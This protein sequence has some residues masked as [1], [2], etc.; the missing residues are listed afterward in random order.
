[1][2]SRGNSTASTTASK[3]SPVRD[4]ET[5]ARF[6]LTESLLYKKDRPY[7]LRTT[8]WIPNPYT[9][10]SVFRITE[11]STEQIAKC[12]IAVA[13]ER[14]EGH[15]ATE[16]KKGKDYPPG[17]RTFRYLGQGEVQAAA[18]RSA[19]FEIE[20]SEPPCRHADIVGWPPLT[21]N[22][23]DNES[24]QLAA[25]LRFAAKAKWVPAPT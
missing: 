6:I 17:K 25:A 18:I 15:R 24:A 20:P 12:G 2:K 23:K 1:M 7:T 5:V 4:D 21:E 10:T 9:K 16:L 14:E 13:A 3:P 19:K 22:R 11:W 8:A